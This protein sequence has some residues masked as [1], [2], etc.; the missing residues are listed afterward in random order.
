MK[1][2]ELAQKILSAGNTP[3][4]GPVATE[5]LSACPDAGLPWS[6]LNFGEFSGDR[7]A[8]V[9][10]SSPAKARMVAA[11]TSDP[12][13]LSALLDEPI[14]FADS[15]AVMLRE[16]NVSDPEMLCE[17]HRLVWESSDSS[18]AQDAARMEIA[19]RVPVEYQL[20]FLS[21][22]CTVSNYPL[23]EA[24]VRIGKA[25]AYDERLVALLGSVIEH[26][27]ADRWLVSRLDSFASRIGQG[28]GSVATSHVASARLSALRP[29]FDAKR[30]EVYDRMLRET[31]RLCPLVDVD[32]LG[33]MLERVDSPENFN[34]RQ[35]SLAG[36]GGGFAEN[37]PSHLARM[38]KP[39]TRSALV[40][41]SR[42]YPALLADV[43][44]RG[45]YDLEDSLFLLDLASRTCNVRVASAMLTRVWD[46][47]GS[48]RLTPGQFSS[49]VAT[50]AAAP[51]SD[52][53]RL[54]PFLVQAV[55]EG[56]E[57][58]A[59]AELV[60][61]MSNPSDF[62]YHRFSGTTAGRMM[63]DPSR[64]D[65]EA[66]F[67]RMTLTERCFSVSKLLHIWAFTSH[68]G[69]KSGPDPVLVEVL[70]AGADS[71]PVYE[72]AHMSE[73][74][75]Y[76]AHVFVAEFGSDPVKW[77]DAIALAASATVPL[78]KV[79]SAIHKLT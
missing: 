3:I 37:Y 76:L 18:P 14:R 15:L 7:L 56:A 23:D 17:I 32:L 22:R 40:E 65:A 38:D 27:T 57:V 71:I 41:V 72:L 55:P 26:F 6:F 51:T 79:V 73:G 42:V 10:R 19:T 62:F 31:Y 4:P 78:P 66:L 69:N 11:N 13:V 77:L 52:R 24:G 12:A 50:L 20:E 74:P 53:P 34:A 21:T 68:P 25:L 16:N 70:S 28:L 49:A 59:V 48:T 61:M 5:L 8:A 1:P 58:S 75:K 9:A 30:P 39:F 29:V 67:A 43:V 33:L 44:S 45:A 60:A 63:Y 36:Q 46:S 35:L 47:S 64:E 54:T 2:H